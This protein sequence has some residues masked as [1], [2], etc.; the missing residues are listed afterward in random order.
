MVKA[1]SHRTVTIKL[2]KKE[3]KIGITFIVPCNN[4]KECGNFHA[5]VSLFSSATHRRD[6]AKMLS[7]QDNNTNNNYNN[8]CAD[9]DDDDKDNIE[10][11][12]TGRINKLKGYL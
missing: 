3:M 2:L 12:I 11:V 10:K 1:D 5:I 7:L 8:N 9:D 6:A 4:C